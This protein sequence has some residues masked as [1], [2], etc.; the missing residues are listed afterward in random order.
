[1]SEIK[2]RLKGKISRNESWA[3]WGGC[4]VILGL[5]LEIYWSVDWHLIVANSIIA[6]GV[7]CE[8]YFARISLIASAHLQNIF[9]QEAGEANVR[10]AAAE[11]K[12]EELRS[13]NLLLQASL[14]PRRFSF[15]GWTTGSTPISSI[16]EELK[17]HSGTH[18]LIQVVPDFE[19]QVFAQDIATTI[20]S[21]GWKS[22]LVKQEESHFSE[23]SITDGIWIFPLTES[24]VPAATA[25]W[26]SLIQALN[27]MGIKITGDMPILM[28]LSQQ[29]TGAA[30]RFNPQIDA[31][32]VRIGRKSSTGLM[33]LHLREL[34]REQETWD[35]QLTDIV[36]A[37]RK[38]M[39]QATDGTMV[40]TAIG[41]DGK[42]I[43]ADPTKT[44][45]IPNSEPTLV[46]NGGE[47]MLRSTPFPAETPAKSE[48]KPP[49]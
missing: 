18:V 16:Y 47:L 21:H 9:E 5:L 44:L 17:K 27:R 22:R 25:L 11:Q 10:A 45:A 36:R 24:V 3:R 46:L 30:P 14:R 12:A 2:E 31:V 7:F 19:A 26:G 43:S 48:T 34:V 35:R 4:G 8:L 38:L 49:E 40:E 1:M 29:Q 6:I 42:L 15:S 13:D 28:T 20:E 41:S 32:F 39:A 23:L 33:E 37:G